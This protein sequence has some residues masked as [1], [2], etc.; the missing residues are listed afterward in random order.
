MST[1]N[2]T[3]LECSLLKKAFTTKCPITGADQQRR[4]AADPAPAAAGVRDGEADS[5]RDRLHDPPQGGAAEG[6]ARR[7]REEDAGPAGQEEEEGAGEGQEGR[8]EP[9]EHH[10]P[11]QGL[12]LQQGRE[13]GQVGG[14][15]HDAAHGDAPQQASYHHFRQQGI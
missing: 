2:V 5:G 12:L 3:D 10:L 9:H 8:E 15:L 6:H 1:K 14:Q 11:P 13:Q 4:G 7:G